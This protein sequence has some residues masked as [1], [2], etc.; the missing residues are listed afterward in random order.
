[1]ISIKDLQYEF[2]RDAYQRLLRVNGGMA[3]TDVISLMRRDIM[4]RTDTTPLAGRYRV[5]GYAPLALDKFNAELSLM[6]VDTQ[7]Q[8]AFVERF[9]L[10]LSDMSFVSE[11]W[12]EYA[13]RI[14][15]DTLSSIRS[16][17]GTRFI[18]GITHVISPRDVIDESA[19]TVTVYADDSIGVTPATSSPSSLTITR[20]MVTVTPVGTSVSAS[21]VGNVEDM[22]T[23]AA[24]AVMFS[25][26]TK[27]TGECGFDITITASF[28]AANSMQIDLGEVQTGLRAT[29]AAGSASS[30]VN[31][32]SGVINSR[33][34]RASFPASAERCVISLRRDEPSVH[35]L[36]GAVYEFPIK[37]ISFAYAQ[38]MREAVFATTKIP[39]DPDI[40]SACLVAQ[41]AVCGNGSITYMASTADE[42]GKPIAFREVKPNSM[43]DLI[44]FGREAYS[45]AAKPSG[46]VWPAYTDSVLGVA[47]ICL[48]RPE[49]ITGSNGGIVTFEDDGRIVVKSGYE[50]LADNIEVNRGYHDYTYTVQPVQH[51]VVTAPISC[52]VSASAVGGWVERIPLMYLADFP[53]SASMI[54]SSAPG[55]VYTIRIPYPVSNPETLIIRT[56]L[57][58]SVTPYL[59]AIDNTNGDYCDITIKA[60]IDISKP[61]TVQ[62]AVP[63]LKYI[64]KTNGSATV[65]SS[66]IAVR[67][68]DIEYVLGT[69]YTYHDDDGDIELLKTGAYGKLVG[70]VSASTKSLQPVIVSFS[71][72][73]RISANR[74]VYE[75]HVY[76]EKATV[77]TIVPF[78]A[79]ESASGNFHR[80]NDDVVSFM[81]SYTLGAGWNRVQTT[82]PYPNLKDKEVNQCSG[83]FSPAGIIFPNAISQ[84]R[85]YRNPMRKVPLFTMKS[86]PIADINKCFAVHDNRVFVMFRPDY[87]PD[88]VL[89]QSVT[90]GMAKDGTYFTCRTPV[91]NQHYETTGYTAQPERI[92]VTIPVRKTKTGSVLYIRA[93]FTQPDARSGARIEK[94]GVNTF[95]D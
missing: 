4:F 70:T 38:P 30:P 1:M 44:V 49:F 35:T 23:A 78:T 20:Q 63:F 27:R 85:A 37:N 74:R 94:L 59:T 41:S 13:S 93:Y 31:V 52:H 95:K 67:C 21:I 47:G 90:D 36:N 42:Q 71:F 61:N 19:S 87:V 39:L 26:D 69:D 79:A 29:I 34:I 33:Y 14:V 15:R 68:G 11:V 8:N 92:S 28:G 62:V 55:G 45:F 54:R 84:Q 66:S 80:I 75:T 16:Y 89:Q 56:N 72:I 73:N 81:S 65:D 3:D 64:E 86:I 88:A 24:S 25:L 57:G 60:S 46:G 17:Y 82:Q 5:D 50:L 32:F 12:K 18:D 40:T 51:N 58:T 2:S 22:F 48:T 7:T 83:I 53:L 77:I 6:T 43:D 9:L 10:S 76:V 91:I